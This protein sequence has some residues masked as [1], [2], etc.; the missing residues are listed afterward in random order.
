LASQF[1]L[2]QALVVPAVLVA[3]TALGAN[4]VRAN[5]S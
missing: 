5:P 4:A 1:S 3:V 2:P